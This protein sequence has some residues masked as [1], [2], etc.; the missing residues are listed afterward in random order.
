MRSQ[1][2]AEQTFQR[3]GVPGAFKKFAAVAAVDYEDRSAFGHYSPHGRTNAGPKASL[4]AALRARVEEV[5]THADTMNG[6]NAQ[7][8]TGGVAA[9]Y[10]RLAQQLEI[11]TCDVDKMWAAGRALPIMKSATTRSL[12][13]WARYSVN[14][15]QAVLADLEL[16]SSRLR[17]YWRRDC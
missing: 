9:T 16:V 14:R 8:Q 11:H 7:A 3:E 13:G 1:K 17:F 4:A 6:A 5:L 15:C 10:E 2:D 12:F